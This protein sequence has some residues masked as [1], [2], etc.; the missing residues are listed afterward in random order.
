MTLVVLLRM[1]ARTPSQTAIVLMSFVCVKQVIT[2]IKKARHVT[3]LLSVVAESVRLT[4]I[5]LPLLPI[6][7]VMVASV[8][9]SLVT[10]LD[11]TTKPV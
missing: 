7:G 6:V 5:A 10:I 3:S 9:V 8:P 1:I 11:L 4:L 2:Q